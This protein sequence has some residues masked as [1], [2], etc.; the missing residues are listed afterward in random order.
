M[1][2]VRDSLD[3]FVNRDTQNARRICALDDEVDAY[4]RDVIAE[5]V[6]YMVEGEIIRHKAEGEP[7]AQS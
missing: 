3:A 7:H 6:V 2:M 1:R 4:N 5:D